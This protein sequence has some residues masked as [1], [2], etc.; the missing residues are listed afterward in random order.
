MGIDTIEV[1]KLPK[2]FIQL[3]NF[4]PSKEEVTHYDGPCL[5]QVFYKQLLGAYG[6]PYDNGNRSVNLNKYV[7]GF[8]I[9]CPRLVA[10]DGDSIDYVRLYT[11]RLLHP[12]AGLE[13]DLKGESK[14]QRIAAF[15]E[16]RK[17]IRAHGLRNPRSVKYEFTLD[18]VKRTDY[19]NGRQIRRRRLVQYNQ[20]RLYVAYDV[21]N[22]IYGSYFPE[23][24]GQASRLFRYFVRTDI[25]G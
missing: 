15:L 7:E 6:R 3:S 14:P 19:I 10:R 22:D 11:S 4:S 24:A 9:E 25:H 16:I 17:E 13:D 18:R 23:L 12:L 1:V 20:D 5:P 21:L 2:V 8:S